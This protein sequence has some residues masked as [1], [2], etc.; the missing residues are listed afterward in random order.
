MRLRWNSLAAID[1]VLSVYQILLP[2]TV[3][4]SLV[5]AILRLKA[6]HIVASALQEDLIGSVPSW[7]WRTTTLSAS[8]NYEVQGVLSTFTP[9]R[10]EES[11][12]L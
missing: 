10:V 4:L 9:C 3:S 1:Q 7:E 8:L 6:G 11:S 5:K 2:R 12:I